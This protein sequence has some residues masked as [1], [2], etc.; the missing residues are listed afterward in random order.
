M[1]NCRQNTKQ[2][3]IMDSIVHSVR[4]L[5]KITW[6]WYDKVSINGNDL[7]EEAEYLRGI[8]NQYIDEIRNQMSLKIKN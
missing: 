6:A 7:I 5:D 1:G 3:I 4:N 8:V 2:E